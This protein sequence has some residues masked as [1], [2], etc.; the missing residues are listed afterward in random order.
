MNSV[1]ELIRGNPRFATRRGLNE[2]RFDFGGPLADCVATA[3]LAR[4]ERVSNSPPPTGRLTVSR[5]GGTNVVRTYDAS[6]N[7]A[8]RAVNI[9]A[10]C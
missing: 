8:S 1:G 2:Y 4:D 10:A 3:S 5:E 9:I 7:P 6:G